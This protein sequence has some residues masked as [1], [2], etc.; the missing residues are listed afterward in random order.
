MQQNPKQLGIRH[1][2]N[3]MDMMASRDLY[4]ENRKCNAALHA[5]TLGYIS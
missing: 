5:D 4:A 3:K 2:R 1:A